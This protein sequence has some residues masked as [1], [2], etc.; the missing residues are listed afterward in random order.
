LCVYVGSGADRLLGLT[1]GDSNSGKSNKFISSPDIQDKP[2][3]PPGLSLHGYCEH[4][5]LGQSDWWCE[6]DPHLHLLT[7]WSMNGAVNPRP[8]M[9]SGLVYG[10]VYFF[11]PNDCYFNRLNSFDCCRHNTSYRNVKNFFTQ[12]ATIRH[13]TCV[14]AMFSSDD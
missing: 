11:L 8:C 3:G 13:Q 12:S 9:S 7:K 10:Q 1:I 4:I 14:D 5:P 2:C 6:A